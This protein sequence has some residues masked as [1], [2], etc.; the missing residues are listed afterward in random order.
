MPKF[1]I[2]KP[3]DLKNG[4]RIRFKNRWSITSLSGKM[5]I[6]FY[7]NSRGSSILL[8]RDFVGIEI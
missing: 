8:P 3:K 5:I 4:Q 2:V 6:I 7:E 1:K